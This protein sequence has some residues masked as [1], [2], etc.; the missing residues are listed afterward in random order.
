MTPQEIAA[1]YDAIAGRWASD[2]FPRENGMALHRK[3]VKLCTGRGR[4]LDAGCGCNGR[5]IDLLLENGFEPMGVDISERMMALARER[6]PELEFVQ[7]DLCVWEPTGAFDFI[8]AWDSIWHIPLSE[9]ESLL[10]RLMG[11]LRPGG[12]FIF[13]MGGLE[14][15]GETFD[16]AMGVP[17]MHSTPG[18]PLMRRWVEEAGCTVR[19]QEFDQDPELHLVVIVQKCAD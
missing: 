8:T 18:I 4:A 3:A 1:S 15:P 14:E 16:S 17:M 5:F 13:S 19:H 6:H 9:H 10:K 11:A 2:A 12:V 7:A